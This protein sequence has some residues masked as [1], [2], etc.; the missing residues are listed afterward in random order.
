MSLNLPPLPKFPRRL[1]GRASSLLLLWEDLPQ[2]L[3]RR[4]DRVYKG[5][6]GHVLVSGQSCSL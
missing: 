4:G 5:L 2:F 1:G 6:L 3:G